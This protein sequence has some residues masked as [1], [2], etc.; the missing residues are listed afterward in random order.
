MKKGFLLS[1]DAVAAISLLL[2]VSLFLAGISFTYAS[3]ELRYQRYYYA[4]KDLANILEETEI[5]AV[6]DVVNLS[7][8]GLTDEDM[9][10]T[11]LDVIGSFWAEG[12]QSYAENLTKEIFENVLNNT[13]LNYEVLFDGDSIYSSGEYSDFLS[14]L[15]TIV[16]GYE[17]TK[18][19]NGY[20]ARVYLTKVSKANSYFSYFGGYVGE[21]NVTKIIPIPV[22]A[23]VTKV[24]M[25]MN[26]GNN[27]TLY[28]NG[29]FSG[30]YN[31]TAVNFSADNWTVCSET[32][33]PSFCSYFTGG[34]NTVEINFTENMTNYIGGG[35]L[36]VTYKTSELTEGEY[37]YTGD[38]RIGRYYFPGIKG[39][40]N[41]Y[42]SFYVPGTLN[43]ISARLHYY[44]NLSMG[45]E[46]IPVFFFIG[47]EEI[48]RS[49]ETGE[50]DIYIN[51]STISSV[52]GGMPNLISSLS[53][54]TIPIRFGTETF[55]FLGGE[56]RSDSVLITDLSGS[57][58]TCDVESVCTPGICDDSPP[59][60]RRRINVA[61]DVDKEFVN[62]IINYT[63]SRAGLVSYSSR[64][65]ETHLLSN[66]TTSLESQ[67]DGYSQGGMTCISCGIKS[68]TNM[69]VDSR[70]VKNIIPSKS[71]W[72][73][74]KS[75][76]SSDP[77]DINV[78]SWTEY[79]YT[80]SGWNEGNA[81]LGFGSG[82]DTDIG[83]NNGNYYFRKHFNLT[84]PDLIDFGEL[85]VLSDD[86]AEVYLNGYLINNDTEEHNATY[87]NKGGNVF[88][89]DFESYYASGLNRLTY[90]EI[91]Q[92]P[93]YWIVDGTPLDEKEVYIAADQSGYP[94]HS[95]TDVLVFSNMD[96]YGYAETYLNLS[97]RENQILSY[98]WRP[99]T[100][101][102][103]SNEYS[104]M[105]IWD[106]SWNLVRSYDS[107]YFYDGYLQHVINLSNYNMVEN[108]TI[109]FGSRS[110][111]GQER[112]YV[113]DVRVRERVLV[114]K[115]Y[116]RSGDNVIAVKLRN[117]DAQSA[118]FDLELNYTMKRYKA[119]LVMSDGSANYCIPGVNCNNEVAA[120]ESI[121]KAC[122]ARDDHGITVYSVA[123]GNGANMTTLRKIACWDCSAGDWI[124]DCN[125]F[126]NSSNADE[127]EEIYQDIAEDIANA[128]YEA[129]IFNIS[130][131]VSLDNVL[132]TDSF[133]SFN[134]TPVVRT[135]EYGELT[136]GFESPRLR[137]ST[138]ETLITD[139]VTGTKEGW[140]IIPS[141]TEVVTKVLDSK[142]TS[143][144]S[145]Y[146]T[147]RLWVNSSNTPNQNWTRVYWLGNFSDDYEELGDPY[148]IQSPPNLLTPGGNNSFKIGTGLYPLPMSGGLG[149]SPDDRVIYTVGI[150]GISL[151]EYSEILPKAE[152]SSPT[153]YYDTNG[154]NVPESSMVVQ[155]G[156]NPSDIFDP[157]NESIDSGF[158]KLVNAMN[159]I[160]DLN[161]GVV[162]INHTSSGP[163]GTGDGSF[164]NP[165][166][167]E[168]TEE[169][170]F[171][172]DFI[173]QIPSMWGPATM[174]VRV[175]G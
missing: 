75:Y 69:L 99:G 45:N 93:G 110:S 84:D 120:N 14:R 173:S 2:M 104:D 63:G 65:S 167:L 87:W 29:N 136:L 4:G 3:P 88:Y 53:N 16:S 11:I 101:N 40:I 44:N 10:R 51:D 48:Y 135:L 153:I 52:F 119:M 98:W 27:F 54:A 164:N 83:N 21:G 96:L 168:I 130:G 6:S 64:L 82:V 23:N 33:S 41:L 72:L 165:I 137:Q 55:A 161:E 34:N 105:W 79:N 113:D 132:Y 148:I 154:D 68:A 85:F 112:F 114:S 43:N 92:S 146:W 149:G 174:E 60:Y 159:F 143:Y 13:G 37:V 35:Y 141:N 30:N 107:T 150:T 155:V 90:D 22:D 24:Y 15:S 81:I 74:N 115:S 70:I 17:K 94:A 111:W 160:N 19:V 95:G 129:Q 147:D 36:K 58:N 25:E 172:S 39:I 9:D 86:N 80:D 76:P 140:F 133:I 57:M 144:S 152:G 126:Y 151:I 118:K 32:V 89:D 134:Y 170:E 47:A 50:M 123:F 142:M 127:L 7:D 103:E 8:Y 49:N 106:G 28:V 73:Y 18:P 12:N 56:G 125:K 145:Y 97:G 102:I 122:E 66:D 156:S 158:M 163:S 77:P 109:K 138:G 108:F 31:R 162:D 78:T 128:T 139:N 67:I 5:Q 91:N 157:E 42:S 61:K 116:F 46:G 124:P 169:V 166:D 175:W 20:L 26:V 71:S 62:T 1:L 38:T 117:N 121:E 131:N 59:C 171:N 100:N